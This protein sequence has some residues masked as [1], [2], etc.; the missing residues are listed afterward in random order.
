MNTYCFFRRYANDPRIMHTLSAILGF[1]LQ[2]EDPMD[3]SYSTFSTS[4]KPE[5]KSE[6]KPESKTEF[7]QMD[8]DS[9]TDDEIEVLRLCLVYNKTS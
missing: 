6:K 7:E 1:S 5:T 9:F 3:T 2:R 8:F 4:A